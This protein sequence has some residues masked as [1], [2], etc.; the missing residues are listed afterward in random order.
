MGAVPALWPLTVPP[1]MTAGAWL[2]IKTTAG[3]HPVQVPLGV[4]EGQTFE[5]QLPAG[6]MP[7]SDLPAARETSFRI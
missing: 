4:T 6:V 2:L 1:G 3:P 7:V 5:V